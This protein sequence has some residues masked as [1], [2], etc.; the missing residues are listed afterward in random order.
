MSPATTTA[1]NMAIH[2]SRDTAGT[3][4]RAPKVIARP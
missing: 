2:L 4:P 3:A 1:M